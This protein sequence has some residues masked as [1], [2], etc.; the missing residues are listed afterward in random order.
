MYLVKQ[1]FFP[2]LRTKN[3]AEKIPL[4]DYTIFSDFLQ[5]FYA[6]LYL[7]AF[8]RIFDGTAKK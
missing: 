2:I 1:G 6:I 7:D 3:Y 5:S 4:P 8:I